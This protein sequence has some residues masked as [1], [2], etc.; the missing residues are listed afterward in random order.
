M[1]QKKEKIH[2]SENARRLIFVFLMMLLIAVLSAQYVSASPQFSTRGLAASE[3]FTDNE[4]IA[5]SQQHKISVV[6]YHHSR[7]LQQFNTGQELTVRRT[8]EAV[9]KSLIA[10]QAS[11]PEY[12]Q[13]TTVQSL[14]SPSGK[15]LTVRLDE[16]TPMFH[17]QHVGFP[18]IETQKR[19]RH[20]Q[21]KPYKALMK[22]QTLEDGSIT[23]VPVVACLGY[24]PERLQARAARY[25]DKIK[26]YAQR[27]KVDS[28]LVKAVI[29]Q[30]SCFRNQAVS[31]AGAV[32]LM[33]LMPKTADWLGVKQINNPWQNLRAGIRYLGQL[34]RRFE[35]DELALAAYNA[36]P[37]NVRRYKGI[38]P[39]SET[40][41]YVQK[42]MQNYQSYAITDRFN[43]GLL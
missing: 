13:H 10:D 8:G 43:A 21:Y 19:S 32:G 34:K 15:A 18:H 35:S 36:G 42:V 37:G 14:G 27:Y 33:Q 12:T 26:Q 4:Q 5:E 29:A 30:E 38:P 2:T 25:E 28:H 22:L 6:T 41:H 11:V 40:Q 1:Y 16:A 17:F 39:F 23:G 31:P 20:K 3:S 9:I 24:S 7:I